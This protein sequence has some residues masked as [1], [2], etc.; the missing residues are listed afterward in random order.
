MTHPVK[1]LIVGL[2]VASVICL[3]LW[4]KKEEGQS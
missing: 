4:K 3:F 1:F 2:A